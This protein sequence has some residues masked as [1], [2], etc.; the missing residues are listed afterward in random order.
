MGELGHVAEIKVPKRR[1][2]AELMQG[3]RVR[4]ANRQAL[5]S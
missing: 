4:P 1:P 5:R 2:Q 3:P